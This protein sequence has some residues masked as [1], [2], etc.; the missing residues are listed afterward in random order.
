VKILPPGFPINAMMVANLRARVRRDV[1]DG[2]IEPRE[3]SPEYVL[4]GCIPCPCMLNNK[5]VQ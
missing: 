3:W 4:I 5:T 2:K 1:K